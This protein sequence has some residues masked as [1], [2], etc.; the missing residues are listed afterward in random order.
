MALN[1]GGDLV[2]S[3]DDLTVAIEAADPTDAW[4]L[5]DDGSTTLDPSDDI[6]RFTVPGYWPRYLM[7][8]GSV[9]PL[10][11]R[12]GGPEQVAKLLT[13]VVVSNLKEG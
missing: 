12:E 5:H 10:L 4:L 13:A 8:A 2:I 3:V 11:D 7:R 9:Q 1:E 6:S